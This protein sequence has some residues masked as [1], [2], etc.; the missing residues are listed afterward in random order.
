MFQG[1]LSLE[2]KDPVDEDIVRSGFCG[3]QYRCPSPL[4][5]AMYAG[6]KLKLK[7]DGRSYRL[8]LRGTSWNPH[9]LHVG[10]LEQMPAER[11][12]EATLRFE[13]FLPTSEG[14]MKLIRG[15]ALQGQM[16]SSIGV[17]LCDELEGPFQLAIASIEFVPQLTKRFPTSVEIDDN[18]SPHLQIPRK[19][20]S[21]AF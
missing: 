4:P 7:S 3:L 20:S 12:V 18:S 8:N 14:K 6:V 15:R 1:E 9:E 5:T 10:F 11:W 17:T 19:D 21:F 13:D 16:I 2:L